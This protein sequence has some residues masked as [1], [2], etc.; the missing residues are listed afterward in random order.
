MMLSPH[1]ILLVLALIF[2]VISM[3][4]WWPGHPLLAIAVLLAIIAQFVP[5]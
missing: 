1:L 3:L 4:P 2:A 5:K